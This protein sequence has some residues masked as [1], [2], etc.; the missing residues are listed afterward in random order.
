MSQTK[1][2][3]SQAIIWGV[4]SLVA[5]PIADRWA[6]DLGRNSLI[7]EAWFISTLL[8]GRTPWSG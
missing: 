8:G 1:F 4:I 5:W 7:V 6:F 2:N 3:L